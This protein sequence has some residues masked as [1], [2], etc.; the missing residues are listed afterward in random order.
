MPV[1]LPPTSRRPSTTEREDDAE[2]YEPE[3]ARRSRR[4]TLQAA[5]D[6]AA[7]CADS[8]PDAF[9]REDGEAQR[10]WQARRADALRVCSGCPVRAAC[11]ELALRDGDGQ[12]AADDMVRGGRTGPELAAA[13]TEH[14]ARLAA[15]TDA[16]RDTEG[17]RLDALVIGLIHTA[18]ASPDRSRGER[19]SHGQAA[20][21]ARI[22]HLAAQIREIRT[23]RR[24]RTGWGTAA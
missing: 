19:G 7:E 21:S 1:P 23:A 3:Q 9:F 24:A 12:A 6:A 5:V 20:Q 14:A 16:D 15:A 4:A 22:R 2:G 17:R 18:L 13:R 10:S 8:D 11:E